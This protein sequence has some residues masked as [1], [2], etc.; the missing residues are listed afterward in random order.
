MPAAVNINVNW[1]PVTHDVPN[2]TKN[3]KSEDFL[4]VHQELMQKPLYQNS[5]ISAACMMCVYGMFV[6]RLRNG[7]PFDK[8]LIDHTDAVNDDQIA[9]PSDEFNM[10]R[11][12]IC[13]QQLNTFT[14]VQCSTTNT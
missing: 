9:S 11:S 4:Q 1:N 12:F 3:D 14:S 13:Q 6:E 5:L 10:N 7:L 8:D 2:L